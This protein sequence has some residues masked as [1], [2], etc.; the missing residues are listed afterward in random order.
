[1]QCFRDLTERIS[2][3]H[4]CAPRSS[5]PPRFRAVDR[6]CSQADSEFHMGDARD[7]SSVFH[8]K[9]RRFLCDLNLLARHTLRPNDA[10][11]FGKLNRQP[12]GGADARINA[13]G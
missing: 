9:T 5:G 4:K 13:L 7:G 11:W 1:M 3:V 8:R 10:G 2:I 12:L 6:K